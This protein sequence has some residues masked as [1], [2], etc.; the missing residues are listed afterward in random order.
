MPLPFRLFCYSFM[1]LYKNVTIWPLVQG[2]SGLNVSAPVPFVICGLW[3]TA[4][5]TASV[6]Y[7][8]AGTSLNGLLLP[9]AGLFAV[10]QRNVTTC[11]LVQGDSG[12][13]VVAPV[14]LAM[15]FSFAHSTAL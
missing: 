8:P 2:L 4:H 5:S 13:N 14:P 15:L 10:L 1:Y 12:E 9:A 7:W 6:K 11:A 3:F